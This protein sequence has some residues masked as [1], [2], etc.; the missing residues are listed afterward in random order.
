M[1]G[2]F[3]KTSQPQREGSAAGGVFRASVDDAGEGHAALLH[4][5]VQPHPVAPDIAAGVLIDPAVLGLGAALVIE[6]T[7]A[8]LH[9]EE[10]GTGRIQHHRLI[11]I[12]C[13]EGRD[14]HVVQE[15]VKAVGLHHLTGEVG[16]D[17]LGIV[18]RLQNQRLTVHIAD[19]GEAVDRRPLPQLHLLAD[20]TSGDDNAEV[21]QCGGGRLTQRGDFGGEGIAH[22]PAVGVGVGHKSTLAP[23]ADHEALILQLTDGLTDGVAADIQRPAKLRLG[24]QQIADGQCAG[25][26]AALDDAHQL[27][28]KRDITAQRQRLTENSIG[29]HKKTVPFIWVLPFVL[30]MFGMF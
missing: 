30:H 20:G 27:G 5:H 24:G 17:E 1:R 21:H 29:F 14:A 12:L 3:A 18:G 25:G 10:I 11:G 28:I 2:K 23:L 15:T 22:A 7:A 6:G 4:M 13:G 9:A 8:R 26:D 19:T 16:V